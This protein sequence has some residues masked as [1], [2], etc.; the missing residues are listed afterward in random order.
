M[1]KFCNYGTPLDE[2]LRDRIVCG[3]HDETIQRKLLSETDLTLTRA[4]E[5]AVSMEAAALDTVDLRMATASG[6]HK[7]QTKKL[8]GY[9]QKIAKHVIAP[10]TV[11]KCYRCGDANH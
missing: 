7:I 6:V 1:V 3:I 11:K 9:K 8:T 4:T 2:M 5:I 10:S